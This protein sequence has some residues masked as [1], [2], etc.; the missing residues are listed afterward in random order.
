MKA[1]IEPPCPR[2][3]LRQA[4][5]E[6][7]GEPFHCQPQSGGLGDRLGQ[8]QPYPPGRRLADWRQRFGQVVE[9]LIEQLRYRFPETVRQRIAR[10][11]IKIAD[12]LQT[13][14][15]QPL[16]DRRVKAQGFDRQRS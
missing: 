5:D 16:G 11:R 10:H 15:P 2:S 14:P 9:G 7:R 13:D 3:F 12:P 8:A 6:I 1:E 4:E